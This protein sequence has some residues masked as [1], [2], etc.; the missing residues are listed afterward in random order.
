MRIAVIKKI[1][2]KAISDFIRDRI[3]LI[4]FCQLDSQI[5]YSQISSKFI[6]V[7]A[8]DDTSNANWYNFN[9]TSSYLDII[10]KKLPQL[11]TYKGIDLRAALNKDIFWSLLIE[12]SLLFQVEKFKTLENNIFFYKERSSLIKKLALFKKIFLNRDTGYV[13]NTG[14][15]QDER[16]AKIAFRVNDLALLGLYGN[17][18]DKLGPQNIISFQTNTTKNSTILSEG[19]KNDVSENI[20]SSVN[21]TRLPISFLSKINLLFTG[22]DSDFM[23]N[24]VHMYNKLCNHVD[25][26]E[27]LFASG[28]KKIVLNAGEN[29]GEGNVACAVAKKYT[30]KTFNYMNGTKA[31]DPQNVETFFDLWFMPDIKTQELILSYCKVEKKQV[32]VTGHLLQELAEKHHYRGSLDSIKEMLNGKKVIA[33]FTS[34]IFVGEINSVFSFLLKYIE[35]HI[36]VIV[37][38]RKHPTETESYSISH[39]RI[40][41]LPKFTWEM[42]QHSLFDLLQN[43]D[44]SISFSSTVSYQSSWFSIPS[45]NYEVSEKS[46]LTFVDNKKVMH[47]NSIEKLETYLNKALFMRDTLVTEKEVRNTAEEIASM[48]LN[49]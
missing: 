30:A 15:H 1:S 26:Y 42:S 27:K 23:I 3:D 24:F 19:L 14:A 31:R 16:A 36:D 18:L 20:N 13:M 2:N 40:I 6:L 43:A 5:D 32:P 47:I 8:F 48:M 4:I 37:L 33:L 17:L 39:E 41:E 25:E 11:F 46:R 38:I 12:H 28:V 35:Q 49:A 22:I 29:E 21:N 44:V 34:K 7:N 45:I 10:A 9:L